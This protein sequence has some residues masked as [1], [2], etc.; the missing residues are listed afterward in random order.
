[1]TEPEKLQEISVSLPFIHY[2]ALKG[3][4]AALNKSLSRVIRE[5]VHD[6]L[7]QEVWGDNGTYRHLLIETGLYFPKSPRDVDELEET[8]DSR[9]H[10]LPPE[11]VDRILDEI[12]RILCK[13]A[14]EVPSR[15]V[16]PM[17]IPPIPRRTGDVYVRK[18]T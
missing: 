14:D 11:L 6:L 15:E 16:L 5:S 2:L 12:E 4:S 8:M 10:K 18:Q 9:L 13:E 7:E 1:M 3:T 17:P